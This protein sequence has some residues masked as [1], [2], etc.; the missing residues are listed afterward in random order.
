MLRGMA[1]VT[2]WAEDFEGAKDWYTELLGV[3]PYFHVPG[4]YYE[5]RIGDYQHELGIL[6]R[7]FAPEGAPTEPGGQVLYWA[8]DDLQAAL[9]RLMELGAKEYQPVRTLTQGFAVAS[10][11]DPFGNV[12]GVMSN[13]HYM[14]VLAEAAPA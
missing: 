13:P 10:V 12:L 5:F 14:E 4:A 2:Y 9:D 8:V 6:N 11:V 1:T 3:E 7:Q